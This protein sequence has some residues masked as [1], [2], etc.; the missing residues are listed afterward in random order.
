MRKGE[1]RRSPWA[2]SA[3]NGRRRSARGGAAAAEREQCGGNLWR[4]AKSP[5]SIGLLDVG[6]PLEEAVPT[7]FAVEKAVVFVERNPNHQRFAHNVVF[8]HKTPEA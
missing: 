5:P 1:R 7:N 8:G 2:Q 6:H 3:K 4:Q